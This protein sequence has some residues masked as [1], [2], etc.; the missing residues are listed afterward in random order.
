MLEV[1]KR[2]S[3]RVV[4]YGEALVDLVAARRGALGSTPT[5][6]RMLGGAPA[7]V[8][9]GLARLG[10][11]AAFAGAVGDDAFGEYL[12]TRLARAGVDVSACERYAARPTGLSFVAIDKHGERSFAGYGAPTADRFFVGG[13]QFLDLIG[14]AEVFHFGSNVLMERTARDA[15]ERAI[16][17]AQKAGVRVTFDPNLRPHLWSSAREMIDAV[18]EFAEL[19]DVVKVSADE[20]VTLPG[21]SMR[22]PVVVVTLG[23]TGATALSNAG[24]VFRATRG[25]RPVDTTGAGDAFMAGFLA[26]TVDAPDDIGH[27]LAAG[28]RAARRCSARLG[29]STW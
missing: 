17:V 28:N 20:L 15:T 21:L 1:T 19:A 14:R 24:D 10:V 29:A 13:A 9:Y 23:K 11:R 6:H 18:N 26:S 27:A 2:D 3:P 5:F 8:A 12:L 7:N 16:H 22:A 4:C 25:I